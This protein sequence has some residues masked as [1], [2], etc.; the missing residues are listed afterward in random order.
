MFKFCN[1]LN[2]IAYNRRCRKLEHNNSP[3]ELIPG[4][5]NTYSDSI[6]VEIKNTKNGHLFI[7]K[8]EGL[9]VSLMQM[10]YFNI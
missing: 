9:K 7:L 3:Y 10:I 4:T 2:V 8:V 6:T 1:Y 5:L